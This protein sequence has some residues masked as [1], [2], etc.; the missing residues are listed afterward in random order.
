MGQKTLT[1]DEYHEVGTEMSFLHNRLTHLYVKIANGNGKTKESAQLL[2]S[3]LKNF[4][5]ARSKLED[6]MFET[7]GDQLGSNTQVFYGNN[8]LPADIQLIGKEK[9]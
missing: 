4:D 8:A 2:S 7:Y 6:L 9:E 1:L 3:S 5:K